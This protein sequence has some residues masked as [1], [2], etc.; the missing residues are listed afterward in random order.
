MLVRLVL[1]TQTLVLNNLTKKHLHE[2]LA[3]RWHQAIE[4]T[5]Y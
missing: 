4:G 3:R 1:L 5:E 2:R